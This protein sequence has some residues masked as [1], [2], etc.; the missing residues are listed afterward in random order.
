MTK[1]IR[2]ILPNI[3]QNNNNWK[4]QLLSNWPTIIG[5]LSTKVQIEKIEDATIV[6]AAEDS[7]WLQELYL[8]SPLLLKT[9]N[10]TLDQPRIKHLRFKAAGIKKIKKIIKDEKKTPDKKV[11]PLAA[12]EHKALE[13]I[14]NPQLQQALKDFLIRCYREST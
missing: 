1:E 5:P 3:L 11:R 12:H 8:L 9:I 14:K 7:C 4:I 13:K 2:S 6:L 10:E